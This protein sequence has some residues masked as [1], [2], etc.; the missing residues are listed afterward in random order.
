MRDKFDIVLL[1]GRPAAGKSEIIDYLKKIDIEQRI[2]K[3]HIAHIVEI[4]DFK[5]IWKR[6][7]MDDRREKMTK[8]RLDTL[9]IKIGGYVVKN[10]SVY[11]KL[12]SDINTLFKEKYNTQFFFKR[13][14]LFIEFSRGGTNG[15]K[16]SL[17]LLDRSLLSRTVIYYVNVSYEESLR[18]NKR[19][20]D[21]DLED[22]ILFHTVP[23]RVMK[24]YR[25]DDWKK[26]SRQK[27]VLTINRT[28][29]P[30][31]VFQNEPEKT[32]EPEKIKK[33]LLRINN[34]LYKNYNKLR[35]C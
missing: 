9:K 3:F 18:K 33:E 31:A 14:T 28:K 32:N 1:L 2:E 20:Y 10:N 29:V 27:N 25:T 15:Y 6:G 22:S 16:D 8:K 19:R 34:T 12:I 24:K 30:Y 17:S 21:P 35:A 23:D 13:N 26:L 4:D 11:K 5:F 7:E